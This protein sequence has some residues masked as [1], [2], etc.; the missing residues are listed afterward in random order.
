LQTRDT[1]GV[2]ELRLNHR[3]LAAIPAGI[4][5]QQGNDVIS[6]T[7]SFF[8]PQSGLVIAR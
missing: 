6:L 7:A 4:K 3:L 8:I 1:G 2:G 5:K